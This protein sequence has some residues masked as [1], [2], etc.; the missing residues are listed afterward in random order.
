[1]TQY[2]TM[3]STHISAQLPVC[4]C[5]C[6]FQVNPQLY[7]M[8]EKQ[9]LCELIDTMINYN[10]TYRQERTPEGQYTY[11]LEPSVHT[12]THT[13]TVKLPGLPLI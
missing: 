4:V 3:T 13:P 5:V 1:M 11:V 7:S 9:Q 10:L 2:K 8:R 6:V 12:H